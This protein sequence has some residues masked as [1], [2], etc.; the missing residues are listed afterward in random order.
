M[1]TI[2]TG[3]PQGSILG[4]LLFLIYMNDIPEA[5]PL[6]KYIIFADD[7]S[8]LHAMNLSVPLTLETNNNQLINLELSKIHDW[9]AVNKL[10]LNIKKTKF[11]IFHLPNKDISHLICS[12]HQNST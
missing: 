1:L 4:P 8:L 2:S 6:F 12:V 5:S 10:S 7:T 11:M 3:V 9:L